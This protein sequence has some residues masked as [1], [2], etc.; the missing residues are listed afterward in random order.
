MQGCAIKVEGNSFVVEYVTEGVCGWIQSS[1]NEHLSLWVDERMVEWRPNACVSNISHVRFVITLQQHYILGQISRVRNTFHNRAVCS[2]KS[3]Q[4]LNNKQTP[5]QWI[6][7]EDIPAVICLVFRA[8]SVL[9]T[10]P[11]PPLMD[12]L[13]T[14]NKK[15]SPHPHVR[16]PQAK[17]RYH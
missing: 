4:L 3:L 9:C 5:R 16:G 10:L 8:R 17:I 1:V 13:F 12:P 6:A 7:F 11:K 14:A 2:P 15:H